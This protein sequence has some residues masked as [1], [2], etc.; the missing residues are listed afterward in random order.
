MKDLAGY[1]FILRVGA[2]SFRKS[3]ANDSLSQK[4]GTKMDASTSNNVVFPL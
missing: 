1:M 2:T 4:Q 3:I